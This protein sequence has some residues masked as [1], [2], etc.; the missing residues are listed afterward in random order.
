MRNLI[1]GEQRGVQKMGRQANALYGVWIFKK[2]D[3]K[4][5]KEF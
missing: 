5:Q 3:G 1:W 2:Y 4:V